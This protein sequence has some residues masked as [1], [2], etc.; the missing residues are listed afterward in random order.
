MAYLSTYEAFYA[1]NSK[2]PAPE[3]PLQTR[4]QELI[5]QPFAQETYTTCID[6]LA[7]KASHL[8]PLT[9]G[10]DLSSDHERFLAETVFQR[11]LFVTHYPKTL[12][13]FYMRADEDGRT[14]ACVDLLVPGLGELIGGSVREERYDEL[15][16]AMTERK[17]D[18][19]A[20][21]WYTDLRRFGT[22]PH[23]G[24]GV[25]FERLVMLLTGL[26]NIR[27]V[28]PFPRY[29]GALLC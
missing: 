27:D 22:V 12:K 10:M 7:T 15:I 29:S 24:F 17:M 11:P 16:A 20:Y 21:S 19:E 9:W 25:G 6:I 14:V 3:K 13:P 1:Q 23:A 26:P 4:L 2:L 5:A 8:P 28:I 18:L